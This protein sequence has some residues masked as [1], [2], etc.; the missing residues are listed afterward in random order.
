MNWGSWM[1]YWFWEKEPIKTDI[2]DLSLNLVKIQE[3][4]TCIP[5]HDQKKENLINE[6]K[7]KIKDKFVE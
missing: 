6:L 3:N 4:E 2:V 1:A 5:P 7:E